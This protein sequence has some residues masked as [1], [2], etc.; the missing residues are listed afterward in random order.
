MLTLGTMFLAA[1]AAG[2]V[3]TL[4]S[5]DDFATALLMSRFY[6][7]LR[8]DTFSDPGEALRGAQLWLRSV[9]WAEEEA[10]LVSR[11]NSLRPAIKHHAI[12]FARIIGRGR[13]ALRRRHS[14]GRVRIQRGIA[15]PP[16]RS[17]IRRSQAKQL[18]TALDASPE[19]AARRVGE[20]LK[21]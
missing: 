3:S 8:E 7:L 19:L 21:T 20:G 9:T 6:E 1:G 13:T 15:S 12:S 5:I 11:S 18:D 2:V 14:L 10:Y 16:A 4:W 17:S